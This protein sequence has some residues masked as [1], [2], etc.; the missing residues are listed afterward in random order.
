[1]FFATTWP[2]SCP[3]IILAWENAIEWLEH[4]FSQYTIVVFTPGG[5]QGHECGSTSFLKNALS[6]LLIRHDVPDIDAESR[7][8]KTRKG[9]FYRDYSHQTLGPY[10]AQVGVMPKRY[11]VQ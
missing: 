2:Y 7:T 4:I 6:H 8:Q 9:N 3:V 10:M 1:M 11:F 5:D